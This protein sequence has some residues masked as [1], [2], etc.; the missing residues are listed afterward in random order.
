M[1]EQ[2]IKPMPGS[3]LAVVETEAPEGR[4][5][6]LAHRVGNGRVCLQKYYSTR[7]QAIE[8]W[9]TLV[10]EITTAAQEPLRER[11]KELEAQ[12]EGWPS[13]AAEAGI[14][15]MEIEDKAKEALE[16]FHSDK[17]CRDL[18]RWIANGCHDTD[19]WGE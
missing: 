10:E 8:R 4:E 7:E 18:L 17:Y 6:S 5:W 12:V 11:I 3:D 16:G 19:Q 14:R 2:E 13:L 15:L 1:S 9:N